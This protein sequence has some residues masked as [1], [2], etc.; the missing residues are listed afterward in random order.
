[1]TSANTTGYIIF[2]KA[3]EL[4]LFHSIR[5]GCLHDIILSARDEG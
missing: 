2:I 5:N 4:C 1:M 3:A